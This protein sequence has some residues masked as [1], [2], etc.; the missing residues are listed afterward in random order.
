[1]CPA[2]IELK[3]PK[4]LQLFVFVFFFWCL[5]RSKNTHFMDS[6]EEKLATGGSYCP[7]CQGNLEVT[8]QAVI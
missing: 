3:C 7:G 6:L 1:M 5:T 4:A 2:L 8:H